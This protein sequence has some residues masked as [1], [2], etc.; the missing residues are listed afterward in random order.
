M[1]KVYKE[2]WELRSE[3]ADF[4]RDFWKD[5]AGRVQ[6]VKDDPRVVPFIEAANASFYR[7]GVRFLRTR[8]WV[9]CQVP[10]I[11][12]GYDH[13]FPHIHPQSYAMTAVH[14]L[15]PGDK[16]APLHIFD[17]DEVVE[18]IYP[19]PGLTVFMPWD[20]R[21]GVLKNQGTENR[22]TLIAAAIR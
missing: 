19:E 17:G 3:W 18:E 10:V 9:N 15:V 12:D 13:G 2:R 14:Y 21:H 7:L 6:E 16:P 4:I 5:G 22:L 20:C 1:D 11:G 8:A